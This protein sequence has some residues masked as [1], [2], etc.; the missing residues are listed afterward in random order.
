VA[1]VEGFLHAEQQGALVES[2][3]FLSKA[4]R[5]EHGSAAGWEAAHADLLPPVEGFS[6]QSGEKLGNK[7]EVVTEVALTPSLDEISGL[8]PGRAIVT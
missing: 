5:D 7:T 4:D 3:H 8:V 2:F 6:I 1:A